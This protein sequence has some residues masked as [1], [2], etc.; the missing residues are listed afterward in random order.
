MGADVYVDE[1]D[2]TFAESMDTVQREYKKIYSGISSET[3]LHADRLVAN[4]IATKRTALLFSGGLDST[5]SLYRNMSLKPMLIMIFGTTDIPTSDLEFQNTLQREYSDFAKREALT[6]SFVRTNAAEIL[7][8]IKVDRL[9]WKF[10][11][12]FGGNYMQCLAYSLCNIGQTAPLSI[13][14]FGRLLVAGAI[15]EISSRD[16]RTR[17]KYPYA[18]YP[19]TDEKIMW[20]NFHVEHDGSIPRHEKAFALKEWFASHE[21]KLRPCMLVSRLPHRSG[22][23]DQLNCGQCS[24][25]LMTIAELLLAGI[26]PG[27]HGLSVDQA[28]YGRM[29]ALFQSELL[30][31]EDITFWWK[32]VQQ[33][34]PNEFEEE[35]PLGKKQFFEWFK[36]VNLDSSARRHTRLYSLY[37]RLPY[38]AANLSMMFWERPIVQ[39]FLPRFLRN[40]YNW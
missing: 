28:T 31:R 26:D 22:H 33:A 17:R 39:Y 2:R 18:S 23:P 8:R 19:A 27:E 6:L 36:T 21:M 12:R 16:D 3:R 15:D 20:A 30:S 40:Q 1:L 25:C 32:P 13:E 14:K 24:K 35:C 9:F 4:R 38:W 5:Y 10:Q 34:I 11:G 7:D 29:K 37:Q